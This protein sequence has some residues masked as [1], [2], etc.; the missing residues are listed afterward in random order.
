MMP[1]KEFAA[2]MSA[3]LGK[4]RQEKLAQAHKE[5]VKADEIIN[6]VVTVL[7]GDSPERR[8]AAKTLRG[9]FTTLQ[10]A[11]RTIEEAARDSGE[12]AV[13]VQQQNELIDVGMGEFK[14]SADILK[15]AAEI[16]QTSGYDIAHIETFLNAFRE[17][18]TGDPHTV[19]QALDLMDI[20]IVKQVAP[21]IDPAKRAAFIATLIEADAMNMP[22]AIQELIKIDRTRFKE[23]EAAV[24]AAAIHRKTLGKDSISS[25]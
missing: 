5:I 1:T 15:K 7:E 14:E 3:S 16:I 22:V 25:E 21:R 18:L 6:R 20:P 12:M 19:F 9:L 4:T 10:N 13:F 17:Y 2:R 24:E 11:A 8:E 23:L